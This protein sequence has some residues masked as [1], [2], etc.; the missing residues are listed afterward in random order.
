MDTEMYPAIDVGFPRGIGSDEWI[1]AKRYCMP[2]VESRI[3]L[4]TVCL[5]LLKR[6]HLG[7]VSIRRSSSEECVVC[8]S[9]CLLPWRGEVLDGFCLVFH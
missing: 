8:V 1:V 4:D 3:G 2:S 5:S 6:R 9:I 7:F